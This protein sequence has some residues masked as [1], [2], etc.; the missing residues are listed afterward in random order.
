[1]AG[2]GWLAAVAYVSMYLMDS[3][4]DEEG[5]IAYFFERVFK[6]KIVIKYKCNL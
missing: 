2:I 5:S 1:M 6:T 3:P 4:D